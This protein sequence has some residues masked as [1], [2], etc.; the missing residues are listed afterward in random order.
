MS[1]LQSLLLEAKGDLPPGQGIPEDKW[2]WIASRCGL[3]ELA[4]LRQRIADLEAELE[5][6]EDWDGDTRDDIHNA[7][8]MFR[9]IA[10]AVANRR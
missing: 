3:E 1:K 8:L 6:V 10:A 7:L 5:T 2:F 9:Q 4:T